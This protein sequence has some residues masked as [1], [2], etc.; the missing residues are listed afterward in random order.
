MRFLKFPTVIVLTVLCCSLSVLAQDA[1]REVEIHKNVK[2]VISAAGADIPAGIVS[3][4]L[5]FLPLLESVLKEIVPSQSDE[6]ALTLRV[7]PVIKEIG[8]AKTKRAAAR[9]TAFRKGSKQEFFGNLILY[10]YSNSAPVNKEET[11]DFLQK[12]ILAP[13]ECR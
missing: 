3:Q 5:A 7:M 4:Y 11:Q 13:A 9:I 2:M 12:Q 1:D 10:S 8:A 6:C